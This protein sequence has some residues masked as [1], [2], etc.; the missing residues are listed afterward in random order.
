MVK[1]YILIKIIIINMLIMEV[2][3][4]RIIEYNYWHVYWYLK[5]TGRIQY[6]QLMKILL[7]LMMIIINIYCK[8]YSLP[9]I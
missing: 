9:T 3:N 6:L 1:I 7:F 8:I 4:E 2:E 5:S